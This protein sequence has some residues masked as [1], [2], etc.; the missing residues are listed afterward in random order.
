MPANVYILCCS[1]CR[2]VDGFTFKLNELQL[3]AS[4]YKGPPVRPP[5][6]NKEVAFCK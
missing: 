5:D 1:V 3:R 4:Y 2:I 6:Y